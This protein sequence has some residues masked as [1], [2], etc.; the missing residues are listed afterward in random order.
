MHDPATLWRL[1]RPPCCAASEESEQQ[2]RSAASRSQE[3]HR[4]HVHRRRTLAVTA[5]RV[6]RGVIRERH[7]GS[8]FWACGARADPDEAV[9]GVTSAAYALP[10]LAHGSLLA[11]WAL[12]SADTGSLSLVRGLPSATVSALR[13]SPHS[14]RKK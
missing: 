2:H 6:A 13:G 1:S 11:V 10:P 3:H 9:S 8:R 12:H 4:P 5:E 14:G 7:S